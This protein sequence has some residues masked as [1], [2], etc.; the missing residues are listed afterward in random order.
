M[1]AKCSKTSMSSIDDSVHAMM[2]NSSK[3]KSKRINKNSAAFC[4]RP[5]NPA[6]DVPER[7]QERKRTDQDGGTAMTEDCE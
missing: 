4:P 7:K 5:H 2:L 6:F 3:Q 1:G